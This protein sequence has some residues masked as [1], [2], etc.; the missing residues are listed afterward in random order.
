MSVRYALRQISCGLCVL[1]AMNLSALALTSVDDAIQNDINRA[2]IN[3][4]RNP[5]KAAPERGPIGNP[6]WAIPIG[7]LTLTRDRPLFTPSRRPPAPAVAAPPPVVQP[8]VVA[9]PAEPEHPNLTLIGTVVGENEGIG[10]FLDRSTQGFVRLKTGEEHAGWI[11]RSVKSREAT[12]EKQSQTET[13]SL[14]SPQDS[15]PQTPASN[16]QL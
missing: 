3:L 12:L 10:I 2:T 13:L 4:D 15:V 1:G 11:L 7:S 9:R 5:V 14:P 16:E 6:L 8:K